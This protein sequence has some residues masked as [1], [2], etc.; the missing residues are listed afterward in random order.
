MSLLSALGINQFAIV[1]FVIFIFVF[2]YLMVGVFRPYL[3]A[4]EERQ[5]RTVGDVAVAEEYQHKSTELHSQYQD[6]LR[7]VNT[8]IHEIFHRNRTAAA[9]E[10]DRIVQAA[11]QEAN[12]QIEKNRQHITQMIATAS[13]ELRSQTATVAHAI[14]NKLLGQ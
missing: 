12:A 10:Y 13:A 5:K 4:A 3:A 6:K 9:A 14:T 11:R 1:Q 2:W 8:H 7:E